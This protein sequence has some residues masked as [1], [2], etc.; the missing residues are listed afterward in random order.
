MQGSIYLLIHMRTYLNE[1][2]RRHLPVP[3]LVE[4]TINQFTKVP[5]FL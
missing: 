1:R 4:S 2:S 5:L 3:I